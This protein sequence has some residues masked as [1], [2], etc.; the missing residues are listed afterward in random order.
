TRGPL[1]NDEVLAHTVHAHSVFLHQS[2]S[3]KAHDVSVDGHGAGAGNCFFSSDRELSQPGR[4]L[5][6]HS[7]CHDAETVAQVTSDGRNY[8]QSVARGFTFKALENAA[9]PCLNLR[10]HYGQP[11]VTGHQ[12][13]VVPGRIEEGRH[14]YLLQI[15][16]LSL[17][18]PVPSCRQDGQERRHQD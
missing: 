11:L 8:P 6:P 13:L 7:R 14:L 3:G 4:S 12:E 1:L 10:W 16:Q 18:G 15:I 5:P 2:W 17:L 9:E